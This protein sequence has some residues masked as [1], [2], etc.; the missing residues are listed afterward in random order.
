M[1]LMVINLNN[2]FD[3]KVGLINHRNELYTLAVALAPP[4][5]GPLT[6]H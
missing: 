1:L 2:H 4:V 5:V 6:N 3:Y